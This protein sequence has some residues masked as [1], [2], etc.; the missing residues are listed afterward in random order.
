MLDQTVTFRQS[1]RCGQKQRP[2]EIRGTFSENVRRIGDNNVM[3]PRGIEIDIVIADGIV[4][5]D[6]QM[7]GFRE[8]RRI[9]LFGSGADER[10]GVPDTG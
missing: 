8:Y 5:N 7:G 2:C 1:A 6:P 4:G 10:I 3:C 9:D